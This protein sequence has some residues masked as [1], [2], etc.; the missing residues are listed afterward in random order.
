MQKILFI[1]PTRTGTSTIWQMIR[2]SGLPV[3]LAEGKEHYYFD[4]YFDRGATW[5]ER[6]FNNEAN[7]CL[8]DTS[9][10][11]FHNYE[12]I[13]NCADMSFF[14]HLFISIRDPFELSFSVYRYNKMNGYNYGTFSE[15]MTPDV[16]SY[17]SYRER[18]PFILESFNVKIQYFI[19]KEFIENPPYY[20]ASA[21]SSVCDSL[22]WGEALPD[23]G[24]RNASDRSARLPGL[25]ATARS[26]RRA[27]KLPAVASDSSHPVLKA[28][29]N[30][31]LYKD[32]STFEKP[33]FDELPKHI[34]KWIE[35]E[36]A[37]LLENV[38]K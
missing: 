12:A 25:L 28:I 35:D 1:G 22:N 5:F 10:S 7:D 26:V 33:K 8:I 11:V 24:S 32:G 31:V 30:T 4:R 23:V 27:L 19:Y 38:G 2:Q 17:L 6:Q 20:L 15:F 13:K 21:L 36:R 37:F 3:S 18:I 9:P 16:L 34:S 14:D 29:K